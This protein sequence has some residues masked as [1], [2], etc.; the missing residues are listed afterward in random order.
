[1]VKLLVEHGVD[2]NAR[3]NNG[4]GHTPLELAIQHHGHDHPV[5]KYLKEANSPHNNKVD[6]L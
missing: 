5:V 4:D 3:T 6:E 1:V 2:I